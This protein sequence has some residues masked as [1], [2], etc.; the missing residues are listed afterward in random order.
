V[1]RIPNVLL[2]ILVCTSLISCAKYLG[3]PD[4]VTSPLDADAQRFIDSANISDATQRSA[5]NTLVIS[6]KDSALW[7]R[8]RAIYPMVGGTANSTKWNLKNPDNADAAYRLTF[9][10]SPAFAPT[11]VLFP[12]ITDYADT[13][14]SD[15]ALDYNDNAVSYYSRTQNTVNGYDMGCFDH[16]APYNEIAIYNQAD[17]TNWFGFHSFGQVPVSTK[18]LFMFSATTT[19]VTRYENGVIKSAKGGPP[20]E[21]ATGY[22]ILVGFVNGA[23]AGGQRECALATIGQG[24]TD[25]QALAF[26]TIAQTFEA[27]LGR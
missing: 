5:I 16:T 27:S 12:S 13:H 8:F 25:A 26:A 3:P 11:G 18:G 21:G 22:S 20:L 17:A 19:N 6:L 9:F 7:P 23:T 24:L 15:A 14:L 4:T 1:K 10:G 2:A